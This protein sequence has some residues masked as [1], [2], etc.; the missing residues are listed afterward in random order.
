M[1]EEKANLKRLLENLTSADMKNFVFNLEPAAK[2]YKCNKIPL[3]L[4]ENTQN[5]A[6]E[7]ARLMI[8]H[9]GGQAKDMA[10][11]ILNH[12]GRKDLIP[13]EGPCA[14]SAGRTTVDYK[15]QYRKEIMQNYT[16]I[17]EYN[18]LP[19]ERVEFSSR[20]TKLTIIKKRQHL[21][22]KRKEFLA[23][24][25]NH[26]QLM[27][28]HRDSNITVECFFSPVEFNKCDKEMRT[29]VIQGPAGIGKTF[30]VHKIMLDWA[31]GELF[32]DRFDFVFHLQCRELRISDQDGI[33]DLILK[34]STH[35]QGGIKEILSKPE[36]LLFIFDGFDELSLPSSEASGRE[37]S[38][39]IRLL[40][41]NEMPQVSLL[42]TTRPTA[43]ELLDS[44]VQIDRYA[45][46][47]GFLEDEIK[48]YFLKSFHEKE[49][50][51]GAFNIIK[52]ND[53]V[54]SMCFVPIVCWIVCSMMRENDED[55]ED[56]L[57]NV[58]TASQVLLHFLNKLMEHHCSNFKQSDFL[59][60][61]SRLAFHGIQ[62]EK[63]LFTEAELTKFA[64]TISGTESTI[65]S[66]TFYKRHLK[67]EAVYH[68]VHLSIQELFAA[69]YCASQASS[70]VIRKLL[71][72]SLKPD[73]GNL[74]HI[75][76][77]LFGLTNVT[78]QEIIKDLK[79]TLRSDLRLAL[80]KW[81]PEA[82]KWY[83]EKY[84]TYAWNCKERNPQ[85]LLQLLYC[86]Y[87]M[88]DAKYAATVMTELPHL[89]LNLCPLN[90]IDC[91]VVKYCVECSESVKML[92]VR[93]C[94]LGD[95]EVK[96]LW[97]ILPKC[98]SIKIGSDNLSEEGLE[99]LCENLVRHQLFQHIE[100][101][102]SKNG[103]Q[104]SFVLEAPAIPINCRLS[105]SGVPDL[106]VK[107]R[108][109]MLIPKYKPRNFQLLEGN[110][111][112]TIMYII[113]LLRSENYC[114]DRLRCGIRSLE[115]IENINRILSMETKMR[116]M[117]WEL[118]N[119]DEN[120]YSTL[121]YDAKEKELRLSVFGNCT[122]HT[123][124]TSRQLIPSCKPTYIYFQDLNEAILRNVIRTLN[125]DDYYQKSLTIKSN[126]YTTTSVENIRGIL[127]NDKKM[128]KLSW[129]VYLRG[130]PE[131]T[132]MHE[133]GSP[134]TQI[135]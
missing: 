81:F 87:E 105:F 96:I 91:M 93:Y 124:Q 108:S 88:Q 17:R 83:R 100:L 38:A 24:G 131:I 69:F 85:F 14:V 76:H 4:L 62:E 49:K 112:E 92:D 125:I 16:L 75:I 33:E 86:L 20:Y 52:G 42:I 127:S 113:N 80:E 66:K 84:K 67:A 90:K 119:G 56:L 114:V 11:D 97:E 107:H 44:M 120:G 130:S 1:E 99:F 35:L 6:W 19:A 106:A 47:V 111:E 5:E 55:G 25:D 8:G 2:K 64:I 101:N 122:N 77:F 95:E 50:A 54:L 70:E 110:S 65:F 18:C 30:M 72:D 57:K 13:F 129:N 22:E 61:A 94:N 123:I 82:A 31:S 37:M 21:E 89:D 109:Q 48:E 7:I 118:M 59:P 32:Q 51:C 117:T 45:E 71:I 29:V 41:R 58:T 63:S 28:K 27:R 98:I 40:R 74:I 115:G 43:L 126:A 104:S 78:S 34:C 73:H 46:I 79:I 135:V 23:K 128:L 10:V 132:M 134:E 102:I 53:V 39:V 15:D 116:N 12:I 36:R 60:K 3:G 26:L 133:A 121:I 9:Y 103:S 68:F